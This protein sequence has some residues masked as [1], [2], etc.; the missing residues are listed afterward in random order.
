MVAA[1]VGAL[2]SAALSAG[3]AAATAPG[4]TTSYQT[5]RDPLA[6]YREQGLESIIPMLMLGIEDPT[7]AARRYAGVEEGML[8]PPLTGVETTAMGGIED[9]IMGGMTT[10]YDQLRDILAT[11]AL[12]QG[13]EYYMAPETTEAIRSSLFAPGGTIDAST[14]GL[15]AEALAPTMKG[16]F[17]SN[18][19]GGG[20]SGALSNVASESNIMKNLLAAQ[21]KQSDISKYLSTLEFTDQLKAQASD[22]LRGSQGATGLMNLYSTLQPLAELPRQR[23]LEEQTAEQTLQRQFLEQAFGAAAI[24]PV[25]T[26]E[27]G[28]K[29][30]PS[31]V[32]AAAL[33]SLG[34]SLGKSLWNAATTPTVTPKIQATAIQPTQTIPSFNIN[35][36]SSAYYSGGAGYVDTGAGGIS[37]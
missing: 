25:G 10:P 32:G 4:D 34:A 3:L 2:I 1:I 37:W 11:Q 35:I 8:V 24:P 7:E 16:D 31:G 27:I 17:M 23:E 18:L 15:V 13:P 33:G 14:A 28:T 21:A 36:P 9:L 12:I 22:I 30:Y 29:S 26:T 6:A 20:V 5:A 19:A